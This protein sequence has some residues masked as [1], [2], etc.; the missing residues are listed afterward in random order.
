M[1]CSLEETSWIG[2]R[3]QERPTMLRRW[4]EYGIRPRDGKAGRAYF[5]AVRAYVN[6][7]RAKVSASTL[8][9]ERA[10]WLALHSALRRDRADDKVT[11]EMDTL[12]RAWPARKCSRKEPRV[13][14]REEVSA[15]LDRLTGYAREAAT[16]SLL[17]GLRLGAIL[18]FEAAWVDEARGVLTV[19][20]RA[21][22]V[23]EA[24][25]TAWPAGHVN[26]PMLAT[27]KVARRTLQA[28]FSTAVRAAKIAPARFHDLRCTFAAR[29]TEAGAPLHA[30][31]A[32]GGWASPQ[33]FLRHYSASS[34]ASPYVAALQASLPPQG[35][36]HT[37]QPIA[38]LP[39]CKDGELCCKEG[40]RP[41]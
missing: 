38:P 31:L 35:A 24:L 22:K 20:A 6:V 14:S 30:V 25:V 37:S 32:A 12:K 17:T 27:G 2:K 26:L 28:A 33:V 29:L 8:R 1:M 21:Q 18:A 11:Q 39:S 41:V 15:V 5:A 7:R 34:L 3:T 36:S 19:P 9:T 40:R 13:L 10:A 4:A 16:L 23:R